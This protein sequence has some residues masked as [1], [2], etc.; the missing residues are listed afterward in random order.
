MLISQFRTYSNSLN[1]VKLSYGA[2]GI[3]M[4]N[5]EILQKVVNY[6]EA[7]LKTELNYEELA[8][9]V[10]Y[11]PYHFLHMFGDVIGMPLSA[12]ITRRRVKY[13]IYDISK[14]EKLIDVALAY[15]F[16]T[17]SGFFKAFKREFGCSPSK[18]VRTSKVKKPV[19]INLKQEAKIMLTQTELRQILSKWDVDTKVKIDKV[20]FYLGNIKGWNIGDKYVFTTGINI[21]GLRTHILIAELLSKKGIN[22]SYPIKTKDGQDILQ[23][24]DRYYALL[25]RVEGR[26]LT[27]EERYENRELTGQ[28]YGEAIAKLHCVL[29]EVDDDLI[30]KNENLYDTVLNWAMPATKRIMEQWD[31]PLPEE[32]FEDYKANFTKL[33]DKLPK[34]I[35]HRDPNPTN[36]LF[37]GEDVSGFIDFDISERNVRIFDPCYCATGILAE[38]SKIVDG[39]EKWPEILKGIINGYDKICPLSV[40]EKVAIPYV[41]YSIQMIFIAYLEGHDEA[42]EMAMENRK[43]LVWLWENPKKLKF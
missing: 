29:K 22:V 42:K 38:S 4:D 14:G 13:A 23:D 26:Y 15:G 19:L 6:I 30:L 37:N 9:L 8:R 12:Y 5:I 24:D 21:A 20:Y 31:C 35:I 33:Y 18:Y 28:K 17:H 36:I 34:Q 3:Y 1:T 40:E 10:G 32:F 27:P 7:N 39:Y 41:I 16:D 2:G 43:M 11:S 25:H